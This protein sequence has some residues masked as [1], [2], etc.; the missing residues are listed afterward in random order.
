MR[1]E[2]EASAWMSS[3]CLFSS[4]FARGTFASRLSPIP[5]V[6]CADR[7]NARSCALNV[8]EPEG[9]EGT[10]LQSAEQ[11]GKGRAE[12][13]GRRGEGRGGDAFIFCV[14]R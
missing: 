4:L 7:H 1:I 6:H 8:E 9:T 5:S 11:Q 14:E 12:G 10:R 13:G 3:L 2:N